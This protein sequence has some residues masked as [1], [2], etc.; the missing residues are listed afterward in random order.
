MFYILWALKNTS[1]PQPRPPKY[2]ISNRL[3]TVFIRIS[4]RH[5]KI[6]LSENKLLIF[7]PKLFLLKIF[8]TSVDGNSIFLV[9]QDDNFGIILHTPLS[10]PHPI[11]Q[12]VIST[13]P[14]KYIQNPSTSY[15]LHCH[16]SGLSHHLS[17]LN[18]CSSFLTSLLASALD[19]LMLILSVSGSYL[20]YS[21]HLIC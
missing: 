12:K 8:L 6:N 17:H 10:H 1:V 13:I 9:A 7:L 16:N 2:F 15:H 5:Y 21:P 3:L 4:N 20:F 14:S 11:G 18:Y 19:P